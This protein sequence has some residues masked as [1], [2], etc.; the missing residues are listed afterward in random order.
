MSLYST[1]VLTLKATADPDTKIVLDVFARDSGVVPKES[2]Q[3]TVR[4]D[5]FVSQ[6]I[7]VSFELL[8][9]KANFELQQNTFITQ[10]GDIFKF[11]YPTV[12][13]RLWCVTERDGTASNPGG[14]RR[15]LAT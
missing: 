7:A 12:V 2:L 5:T 10:L 8:I 4:F 14:A 9:S 11:R 1:G 6:D 15:L 13:V 3:S